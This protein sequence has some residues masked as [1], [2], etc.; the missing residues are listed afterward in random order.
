MDGKTSKLGSLVTQQLLD[1]DTCV[2][3]GVPMGSGSTLHGNSHKYAMGGCLSRTVI[4][5]VMS[6]PRQ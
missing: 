4:S 1:R 6:S 3:K 5:A 2:P